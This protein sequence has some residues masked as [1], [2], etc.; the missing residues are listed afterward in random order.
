MDAKPT[1]TVTDAPGT[2][3]SGDG[4]GRFDEA[5]PEERERAQA[6][7]WWTTRTLL[8]RRWLIIGLTFLAGVGSIILSLMIPVSYRAETRVMLPEDEGFSMLGLLD[9]VAPGAS[10]LLGKGGGGSTRYLSILTSR[11]LLD[12][13]VERFNLEDVYETT[14]SVDPRG[15]AIRALSKHFEFDVALDFDYLELAIYDH[16]P[17]Q[18]AAMANFM[19]DALNREHIRLTAANARQNREFIERRLDEAQADLDSAQSDMQAFQ[20]LHGVLD[21]E[22]QGEAFFSALA[23]TRAQVTQLEVEYGM[24]RSQYGDDNPQVAA[25]RDALASAR[26]SLGGLTNGR[27]AL[28]PVALRDLPEVSRRYAELYQEVLTQAKI[29]EV[30]Q[31]LLEQARFQEDREAVAVQVLDEAIPPIRKA[32][33]KRAYIVIAATLSV[34]LLTCLYVIA[35]AWWRANAAPITERLRGA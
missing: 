18:A 32:K 2:S 14:D 12:S 34:L 3:T 21:V 9:S 15:D 24:L 27:D 33:P 22:R 30:V 11:T 17:E 28:L 19:V 20:E 31:P 29:I 26:A 7:F 1:Y 13:M 16:D 10:S 25:A 4:A 8:E 23:D 5:T 35:Q 6:T